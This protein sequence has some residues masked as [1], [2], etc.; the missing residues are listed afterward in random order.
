MR[1]GALPLAVLA[2]AWSGLWPAA[3]QAHLVNTGI[4]P[5]YDGIAHLFVSFEDLLPVV[6]LALLSGLNGPAAGRRSIFTLPIAWLLG[7]LAGA[8]F[9]GAP[10]PVGPAALSLLILGVLVAAD[11]RLAPNVVA[12]LALTLGPAHGW[13][14][15][16]ATAAA[17]LQTAGLMGTAAAAF[18]LTVLLAASVVG[19]TRP[20]T[21]IAVRVGGSWIAASGL[22]LF[23]WTLSGRT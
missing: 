11:R 2:A 13:H 6:A 21:R 20:W 8:Q 5:V 1:P 4:G 9:P 19:L 16:V 23:G 3:A 17:G 15:G 22:L 18:G 12:A 7:G 14:S 10:L